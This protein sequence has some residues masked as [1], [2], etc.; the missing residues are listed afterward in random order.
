MSRLKELKHATSSS[1]L[2]DDQF[3]YNTANQISQIAGLSATKNYTYDNINRL[4][5]MTDGTN[6]E[7]YIYDAVG[8]RT[9]S[10]LSASYTTGSFNRLTATSSASYT[11][12]PNGSMTGKTVGSTTWTYAWDRENRMVSAGDGT[13][14]VSYAYDAL[15]RRVKRTQGSDVQKYTNDG[16]DVVLD[17]INSTITK[18]QNGPGIDNKL[19]FRTGSASKYFLA[20]HLSSTA[21]IAN[22]SGT[23]VDSNTYDSF[24]NASNGSFTSRY[25]FTG[26]EL[27]PLTGLQFSR[28]RF[29]DRT[30][31]KFVSEDPIGFRGGINQYGYVGNNSLN[32][33]D[34][35]GLCA[36]QDRNR[37]TDCEVFVN[38]LVS[39]IEFRKDD[40]GAQ[41]RIGTYFAALTHRYFS[42]E[43]GPV[44]GF[45]GALTAGG[46]DNDVY[47]HIT[48]G[49]ASTLLDGIGL[50]AAL[51]LARQDIQI[52]LNSRPEESKA[53]KAGDRAGE[54]VGSLIS[55]RIAGGITALQLKEKI[56]KLL[57]DSQSQRPRDSGQRY[58]R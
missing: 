19:A 27:D 10:H 25:G 52:A 6:T 45:I 16:Q 41:A 17:D 35:N 44:T 57:C 14:S 58:H 49:A 38:I 8:N 30:I 26:R 34:P 53:S 33:L 37:P 42:M 28:A 56:S 39:A 15:G 4:T 50:A 2:Y 18:Y 24:G 48:F 12:N 32:L 11:Y 40:F 43:K 20:D 36:A 7:S 31:G 54:A 21:V 29:Y 23:S 22:S 9:A 1:T 46:Q 51:D 5:G 55:Q 3:T 13:N 47:R